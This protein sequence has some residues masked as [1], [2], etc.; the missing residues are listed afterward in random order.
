MFSHLNFRSRIFVAVFAIVASTFV[1]EAGDRPLTFED[2]MKFR[3]IRDASI[4]EDG[5]WVAYAL[6]PDRGDGE[7]VV[8][9]TSAEGVFRIERA[10]KP[11]I[12]ADGRWVAAAISPK[13]RCYE[14]P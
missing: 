3:Q 11:L 14:P 7:A 6:V 2:L 12:S 10:T 1:V 4:S 5:A 13:T 9:S 8:R